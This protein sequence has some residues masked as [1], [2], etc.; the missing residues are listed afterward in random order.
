[1]NQE[2]R[3]TGK[4]LRNFKITEEDESGKQENRKRSQKFQN[5]GGNYCLRDPS[6]PITRSWFSG[7]RL[8][9][10]AGR[11]I[12]TQRNPIHPATFDT[13]LLPRSP[14]RR[15]SFGFPR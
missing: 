9:R 15:T 3:K 5:H 1:M 8:R 4:D 6:A 7:I 10:S 13:A 12:R 14:N 11:R 2:N